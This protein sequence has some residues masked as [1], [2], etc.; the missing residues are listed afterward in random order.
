MTALH[1]QPVPEF[2][3]APTFARLVNT[4]L[5]RFSARRFTRVVL[6]LSMVGYIGAMLL[7]WL[8]HSRVTAEDIAQATVQRDQQI[9]MF[10]QYTDECLKQPGQDANQCGFAPTAADF[11]IDQFLQNDPFRPEMVS[12]YVLAVGVAVAMAAFILGATFIGAE[13]SSKN[14]VAWLFYEPRR[15][16]LM[17]AK[18]LVLLLATLLLSIV[19]QAIW[20]LSTNLLLSFRGLPVS[21]LGADAA[22]FWPDVLSGQVRSALLVVPGALLGFALANL[23]RNTAAALGV[24]FVY[25]VI[26]ESVLRGFSPG[27]QP[28]QFTTSVAAW[29]FKGGINVYGNPIYDPKQGYVTPEEIHVSNLH[30]A[31]TLML[32]ALIAL[33][34]SLIVFRRRDIT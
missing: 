17:A 28:Y 1:S 3:S 8:L 34:I 15:M 27:L 14:L 11:P 20:L 2:A 24:A 9:V 12:D 30:G 10:Q 22:D 5:R 7:L 26:V 6:A 4:E 19:A 13:W 18:L 25:F 23:I 16:R 31:V 33:G 21:S 29:V 32:Y